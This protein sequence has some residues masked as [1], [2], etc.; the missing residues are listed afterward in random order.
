MSRV[1][2]GKFPYKRAKKRKSVICCNDRVT[3]PARLVRLQLFRWLSRVLSRFQQCKENHKSEV[4]GCHFLE[5]SHLFVRSRVEGIGLRTR[6][7]SH[8]EAHF[9][10]RASISFLI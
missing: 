10:F 6:S 4:G 3:P 2:Q 1:C 7:C 9:F 8:A 5:E